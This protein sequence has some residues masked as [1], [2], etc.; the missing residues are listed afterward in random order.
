MSDL[1]QEPAQVL[2][3]VGPVVAEDTRPDFA[4]HLDALV[5]QNLAEIARLLDVEP[6]G[7]GIAPGD[8]LPPVVDGRRVPTLEAKELGVS[9]ARPFGR[10]GRH[11]V[12][13][14][15]SISPPREDD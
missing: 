5:A 6:V 10:F 7:R 11:F 12:Y 8:L 14:N 3:P 2:L 1:R 15:R 9:E 13:L 4:V